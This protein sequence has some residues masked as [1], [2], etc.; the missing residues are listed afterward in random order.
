MAEFL[1]TAPGGKQYKVTGATRDGALEALKKQLGT[2]QSPKPVDT[3]MGTAFK[4][5]DLEAQI[6]G[7]EGKATLGRLADDSV[8]GD[9]LRFG[10]ENIGNPVREALGFDPINQDAIESKLQSDALNQAQ[11]LRAERDKLQKA[12]NFKNLTTDDINSVSSFVDFV[13]QKLAQSGPQM[14]AA[15]GSGGYA[16]YPFMVGE[17]TEAQKNLE[18]LT[19]EQKDRTAALGGLVMTALENLG[20]AKL[21]PKGTSTSIIGGIANGTISEGT[22]EGFQELVKIGVEYNAGKKFADG[23][24]LNRLKEAAAAGAAAGGPIKGSGNAATKVSKIFTSDGNVNQPGDLDTDSAK[25]AGDFAR[26]LRTI[27]DANGYDLKDVGAGSTKGARETVDKAHIQMTEELKK[28]FR[29]LGDAVKPTDKETFQE[30]TDKILA[31]AAYRE[32]RNKTK[33]TVGQQEIDA[34]RRLVGNTAEG[35]QALNLMLQL[36][37][38]TEVHNEGYKGGLSRFTDVFNPFDQNINSYDGASRIVTGTLSPLATIA[39]AVSTGGTSVVPQAG[40]YGAGRAID[41]LTGRR[42]R[43]DRY[44]RRNENN[45]PGLPEPSAPSSVASERLRAQ[46]ADEAAKRAEEE[47]AALNLELTQKNAPPTPDSPQ[48]TMEDATGLDRGGVAR[49]LRVL[50]GSNKSK[51]LNRAITEYEQSVATG[52]RI[53]DLSPLI[54]AVRQF[55]EENPDYVPQVRPPNSLSNP[56]PTSAPNAGGQTYGPRYTTPENYNRGIQNNIDANRE[57]AEGVVSDPD[58]DQAQ[59]AQLLTSLDALGSNLGA[60]PVSA[61]QAQ[62]TRLQEAGVPQAAID[63]YVIPYINRVAGQQAPRQSTSRLAEMEADAAEGRLGMDYK[64][65][66]HRIP[67]LQEGQRKL[68]AN[69]ITKEDYE[70]LVNKYKPV[71]P[72]TTTPDPETAD[73]ATYALSNGKGQSEAKAAKYGEPSKVLKE[74]ERVQL[75][76]DIP[77]YS[78]HGTWVVSVHRSNSSPDSTSESR[79]KAGPVVGYESVGRIKNADLGMLQGSAQKIASGSAKGTIATMLGD[80]VPMTPQEASQYVNEV[81]PRTLEPGSGYAQ[82]GMD[83]ER[84]S[85]FYDRNTMEPIVSASDIVQIGPLVVAKDPVYAPKSEFRFSIRPKMPALQSYINPLEVPD[86]EIGATSLREAPTREEL[87]AM[88][89]GTFKPKKKRVLID[90]AEY[91]HQKWKEATGRNEPFEYTPENVDIIS[92]YMATEAVNA[93][94]NDTNAIG[95]YDRKLKAAKRVVSIADPRVTQSPDAEA[96]FDFALAVTSNGQAVADN[97][98]YALEVFRYFMDNGVMPT[99]TWKKGGERSNAMVEAFEFFNAYQA[100]GQNTPIQEFLDLDFTVNELKQW[101]DN[102]NSRY[103]TQIKVPSSEGANAEV[104]GSYIIGP[105]IG[106]GFYQNIRGNYDPLT[107]DIWWMRMWNR[108]V[109]RPFV[110]DPNLPQGR[111]NVKDA[112]KGVGEL[113]QRMINQ[114]LKDMGVGKREIN[115]DPELFDQFV[116]EVEKRY[117]KFY[118]DYKQKN[119]KNHVKPNFFK[120]TGTHV[121]NL[122]PQLQAQPKGPNERAYMRQVTKAAIAKLGD[123]GYDITTADFQALMWYPEKQLFRK[124]GVAPGRGA[125]NDYLDAAIML[126]ESEGI[127]NDQIQEALPD[128]NGDGEV[129]NQSNTQGTYETGDRGADSTGAVTPRASIKRPILLPEP[130]DLDGRAES[131]NPGPSSR[132]VAPSDGEVR[133][134]YEPTRALFEVGKP[135]SKYENGIKS[136]EDVNRLAEAYGIAVTAYTS[137]KELVDALGEG[138]TMSPGILGL[139][140]PRMK[141]VGYISPG[142]QLDNGNTVN[143]NQS[144]ITLLHEVA[145]SIADKTSDG[146]VADYNL[147]MTNRLTDQDTAVPWNSWEF[148]VARILGLPPKEIAIMRDEI[149]HLQDKVRFVFDDGT[150]EPT[151]ELIDLERRYEELA[152]TGGEKFRREWGPLVRDHRN[153]VRNIQ[154]MAVDP[155]IWYIYNPK[156]FKK[157]AP[158]TADRLKSFFSENKAIR[159]YNHP[160]AMGVAVILAML[161]QADQDDE[162]KRMMPPGLLNQPMQAGALSA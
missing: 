5:G 150:S 84:H 136:I 51:A 36:N 64:D 67:E 135:G 141:H 61:A 110:D 129:N 138:M 20:I 88:R 116:T 31:Q 126:A 152:K 83:P 12:T 71:M 137:Q 123:L 46:Q 55:Q 38:L 130:P 2:Q 3:S 162:Q 18:G 144:F 73:D 132:S 41:K 125:D 89:N 13:T 21:L 11:A 7:R 25:A 29:D 143:R 60:D 91:M 27:A 146:S 98:K 49:I 106:Q 93:L 145:H 4:L 155:L 70:Q 19:Q 47:T 108:L 147:R 54:R 115:K 26:R 80:Y 128:P 114:T 75:R 1:I 121:K 118:K 17:L 96:A 62:V 53:K 32:A 56:Q 153:Y 68:Q 39:G 44:V 134:Q 6:S 103:G 111:Q 120:K 59:K 100:S 87:E 127:T 69:E 158:Y 105:K 14:L 86:S 8:F 95:W 30:T 35:Q 85:Y 28:L 76:L 92:T 117:Q 139:Y 10:R 65:V 94:Q 156:A 149:I 78:Q 151:R 99:T 33:S 90:A 16:T 58:L 148:Q 66:T 9:V 157:E 48:F 52:G 77:S 124:L 101:A 37:Q 112:M 72:Y 50:K 142:V 154:E 22:T 122:K 102:F 79:F 15:V 104:K 24:V 160:L 63:M 57:L 34:M 97:F 40:A 82:V 43:V 131:A 81:L 113:E 159:F 161:M 140:N 74:G 119:G 109:G 107:M 42:S 133:Q 23:E 45:Q